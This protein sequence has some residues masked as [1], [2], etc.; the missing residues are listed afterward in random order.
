MRVCYFGTYRQE[1][2]RNQIMIEGLRRAGV[3]VIECHETLWHGLDDRVQAASGK[4]IQPAFLWRVLHTYW[5]LLRKYQKA[6]DYDVLVI[7]YP[8]QLDV[9]MA[10]LLSWLRHKPLVWDIFMSIYLISLERGLDDKSRFTSSLLRS[11]ESFVCRL[12]DQLIIDTSEYVNWFRRTYGIPARRFQLVPTGADERI[13]HPVISQ[14]KEDR[15]F[16]VVYYG[17]FIRNHGVENII[18][19]ARLLA[20]DSS[21]LFEFIGDGPER[22]RIQDLAANYAL[23]N[24]TFINWLG[25]TDLV[26]RVARVDVCLGAFGETPQSLMTI[27][28]KIYEGLAMAKPVITGVSP[29]VSQTLKH[30]ENIYLCERNNPLAL[31]EAIQILRSDP[32]LCKQLGENGYRLFHEKYD[33]IHIGQV[34]AFILRNL[35][36]DLG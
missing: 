7:G 6:G 25:K 27:Q 14:K 30:G 35:V 16:R 19:A 9:C 20:A 21:I 33:L 26:E 28:N 22:Q 24:V 23:D 13:Y 36:G 4:W 8:G 11:L 2:S 32:I 18:E 12:P 34:F 31:A 15:S 1:Y 17:T 10:R 29:A 5:N 3:Q